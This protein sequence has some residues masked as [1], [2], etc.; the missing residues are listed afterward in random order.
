MQASS[1][2]LRQT[3]AQSFSSGISSAVAVTVLKRTLFAFLGNVASCSK[4]ARLEGGTVLRSIELLED[5]VVA[6]EN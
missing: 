1:G 4:I 6:V 3:N 5:T 2:R